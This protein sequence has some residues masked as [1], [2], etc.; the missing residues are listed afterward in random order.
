MTFV[1]TTICEPV[2]SQIVSFLIQKNEKALFE[3]LEVYFNSV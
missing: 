3:A 2:S 1:Y